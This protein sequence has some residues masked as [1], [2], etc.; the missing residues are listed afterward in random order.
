MSNESGV[1]K[2]AVVA[3]T[4]RPR[5]LVEGLKCGCTYEVEQWRD[6]QRIHHAVEHNLITTQGLRYLIAIALDPGAGGGETYTAQADWYV[7]LLGR[8]DTNP[9]TPLSAPAAGITYVNHE[10]THVDKTY[11]F[12]D[13][14]VSGSAV[15]RAVWTNVMDDTAASCTNSAS[16]A[17]FTITAASDNSGFVE[18]AALVSRID[19]GDSTSGDFLLSASLFQSVITV[20]ANDIVNVTVT[21]QIS[22][23]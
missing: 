20:V 3:F 14:T 4:E 22:A 10:T 17:I 1:A 8:Q 16:K 2:D 18:G 11:E 23:T 5:G 9:S 15:N 21:F 6:G 12:R 19:K 7:M 13:C